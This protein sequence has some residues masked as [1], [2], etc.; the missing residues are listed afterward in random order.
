[1]VSDNVIHKTL[2]VPVTIGFTGALKQSLVASVILMEGTE[3]TA[4]EIYVNIL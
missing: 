1:M 4:E 3:E 2:T